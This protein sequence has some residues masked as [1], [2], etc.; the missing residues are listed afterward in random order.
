MTVVSLRTAATLL[1]PDPL[2]RDATNGRRV[3][4][5]NPGGGKDRERTR[6]GQDLPFSLQDTTDRFGDRP[7][8]GQIAGA[9][10]PTTRPGEAN[11]LTKQRSGCKLQRSAT[12]RVDG[13]DVAPGSEPAADLTVACRLFPYGLWFAG[14]PKERLS[15]RRLLRT[16][17]HIGARHRP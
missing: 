7:G 14:Q 11:H 2:G 17:D 16:A 15:P 9:Q 13:R 1:Q 5:W 4:S 6:W 12:I 8:Q 10:L 3:E